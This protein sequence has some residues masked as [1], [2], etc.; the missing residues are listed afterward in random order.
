VDSDDLGRFSFYFLVLVV[1]SAS[2]IIV[3]LALV[4]GELLQ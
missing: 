1:L 2:L 3:G 4:I